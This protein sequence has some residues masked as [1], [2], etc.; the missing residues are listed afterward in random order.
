MSM[1]IASAPPA[2]ALAAAQRYTRLGR[3]CIPIPF[4]TKIPVLKGWPNLH[5]SEQD[6]PRF[7]QGRANVGVLCGEPSG[8]LIDADADVP[9]AVGAAAEFL[10]QTDL[11]HGRA[12]SLPGHRWFVA[13]AP[14]KTTRFQFS[15]QGGDKKTMLI[16]LRSSGCQTVVPPSVYLERGHS[17]TS[18]PLRWERDGEPRR[19]DPAELRRA[20]AR[21]AA[22]ALLARHWPGEGSRDDAAMALA[23]MVVRGGWSVEEAD[24]FITTT[25]RL[26][27]DDE[28]QRRGKASQTAQAIQRGA[29]VTGAR[30]L[31]RLL[32]DGE[33]VVP[34]VREWLGL[35]A[36]DTRQQANSDHSADERSDALDGDVRDVRAAATSR[37]AGPSKRPPSLAMHLISL[38]LDRGIELFADPGGEPYVT[39]PVESHR[40]TWPLRG[41]GFQR[42]LRHQL[43]QQD[44]KAPSA[45]AMQE[46]LGIL[47]GKAL[48]E[49]AAW[50]V[51][52]R[53]AELDSALY[54]DLGDREWRAIEITAEGWRLV[55]APPVKFRR[56]PGML[57]LPEPT[58]GGDLDML[59][60]F[61]NVHE[62]DWPLLVGW[63]TAALRPAG[64]FPLLTLQGQQ[65]SAKTTTA[66]VLR[67]LV[68]PNVAPLR[69][70]PRD[71][72]DLAIVANNG[73]ALAFDNLSRVAPWLS[74]ALCRLSTGGGFTTRALYT[75]AE[76]VIFSAQRPVLLTG[77]E[78]IITRS[79]LLDRAILLTQPTI[80]EERRRPE[81]EFWHAFEQ[82]HPAILGALL[83]AVVG[84]LRSR[85]TIHL[86]RLPRLADFALWATAVEQGLGW[87]PGTFMTAYATQRQEVDQLALEASSIAATLVV[88]WQ[89]WSAQ[90][91]SRA[92]EGSSGA[93][94]EALVAQ[95]GEEVVRRH[96]WP[97]SPRG[98]SGELARIAPNLRGVGVDVIHLPRTA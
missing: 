27:G 24:H 4:G 49:G 53:I 83:D 30:T 81:A 74:D 23:G 68:D 14:L 80:S 58:R 43:Y 34:Q 47:E 3:R 45:Q 90:H 85:P 26:A 38:A 9:E 42:W 8:W 56:A 5:L 82:A 98:L 52:L 39:F 22:C 25:A 66:R 16:E 97:D 41:R 89:A 75:D 62:E 57:P 76:E 59:Q 84:A 33:H 40:E 96:R 55:A 36:T 29:P 95:A 28:W 17:P 61:V 70:E 21:V 18:T 88:W 72:R 54:L 31:R 86:D 64:P 32:R 51:W 92:W 67:A 91:P 71:A 69:T 63:L 44:A 11:I 20:T 7:F 12:G 46:A 65:G 6:L 10:P 50:R 73:W 19:V 94:L 2:T 48:F 60:A 78:D 13:T 77:I 35:G 15:E 37:P 1:H 79:D 87:K 93:L